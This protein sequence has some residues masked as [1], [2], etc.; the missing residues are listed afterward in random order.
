MTPRQYVHGL[1]IIS[2]AIIFVCC[3]IMIIKYDRT[4]WF[5]KIWIG[6]KILTVKN[7]I[8][9][10]NFELYPL[11]TINSDGTNISY[12]QNYESLLKHS[13]K[14]CD[15]NYKKC[16]ILDTYGNIMCIPIGEECPINDIIIDLFSKNEEY[17]LNGY[18][19]VQLE[20][21]QEDY[22]LYYTNG[23]I[24]N[25]I[26]VKMKFSEEIP[27]IINEDN[28]IFDQDTYE[29]YLKTINSGDEGYGGYGGYDGG[30]YGGDGGGGGGGGG[31]G[32]G[33]G[34]FRNLDDDIFGDDE[35]DEY[36][37]GKFNEEI[38]IDKSFKKIS[39]NLY[40]GNYIGF[41]DYTNMNNFNNM[42]LY[43]SYFTVF[44]NLTADVFC[45]FSLIGMICLSIFSICRFCHED[46]PN[47]DFNYCCV[48]TVKIV[49]II[50]YLIFFTGYFSYCLY[51]YFNIYKNR[52]PED[53]I[54][55]KADY[56]LENLLDEIYHRHLNK[57]YIFYIIILLSCSMFINMIAWI[58]S[59]IFTIRYMNL[60]K[61]AHK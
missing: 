34:G 9:I 29:S 16:G 48:C 27:K 25:E 6:S 35:V 40:V 2:Y 47:E 37:R 1:L 21:L 12:N 3:L 55:I 13:G 49:I 7:E 4:G 18:Q 52:N 28:F 30:G 50:I 57:D 10:N 23:K 20:N 39:D 58:L 14:E 43:E 26:I 60:L 19:F 45:Y 46:R 22:V 33:G 56:F 31:I 5:H 53:L 41:K 42:D 54:N 17:N 38:N 61:N 32:S 59:T 51:E 36:L 24:D 44:P 15:N 8:K 11:I